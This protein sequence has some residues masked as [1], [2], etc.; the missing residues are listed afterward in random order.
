M[1]VVIS[2]PIAMKILIVNPSCC[3]CLY[4]RRLRSQMNAAIDP[5]KP[6]AAMPEKASISG[7]AA[8]G[9]EA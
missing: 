5:T 7:T 9:A 2:I 6:I 1:V 3:P 8:G 4:L